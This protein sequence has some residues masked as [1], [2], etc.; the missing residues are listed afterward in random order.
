MSDTQ[1]NNETEN[2]MTTNNDK[3]TDSMQPVDVFEWATG[4]STRDILM[5]VNH[6]RH[7]GD[8][9]QMRLN[10]RD[11]WDDAADKLFEMYEASSS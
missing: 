6:C 9:E 1:T 7:R 5:A 4:R 3:I 8:I 10:E 11:Q 2:A